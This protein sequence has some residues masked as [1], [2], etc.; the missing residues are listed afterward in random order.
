LELLIDPPNH[1]RPHFVVQE[2]LQLSPRHRCVEIS[3]D[4]KSVFSGGHLAL[5]GSTTRHESSSHLHPFHKGHLHFAAEVARYDIVSHGLHHV[6][7]GEGHR[8]RCVVWNFIV[9]IVLREV[10]VLFHGELQYTVGFGHQFPRYDIHQPGETFDQHLFANP[11]L[12]R[13]NVGT[14]LPSS[15]TPSRPPVDPVE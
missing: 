2:E 1:V 12:E 3:A 9:F 7:L 15:R 14:L 6:R 11:V 8:L 10:A 13:W 5:G 4:E